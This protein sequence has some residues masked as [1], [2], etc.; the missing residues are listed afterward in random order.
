[1]LSYS[2]LLILFFGK[3]NVLNGGVYDAATKEPLPMVNVVIAGTE[4]GTVTDDDGSYSMILSDSLNE[5]QVRYSMIGYKPEIRNIKF[6]GKE[7]LT[8]NIS[9][10]MEPLKAQGILVSAKKKQFRNSASITPPALSQKDL[11]MLPSFVE[12]DL[13][14]TIETLPGVTKSSDFSTAVSVR[15]GG[16]DQNLVLIDDVPL[17]NPFHLFGLVSAFNSNAVK[18]AELYVSGIPIKDDASLS[19]VLDLKTKSVDREI[20]GLSGVA[21]LS[22]LSGGLTMGSKIPYLNSSFL[23]SVRRTYADKLLALFDYDLPY[24]F[25]DGY[26]HWETEINDWSLVLSGYTGE[27]FL[28]IRDNDDESIKIIG[29]DWGNDVVALN[30]FHSY[31]EGDLFHMFAGYS[32]HDFFLRVIDTLFLTDGNIDVGTIGAE[33]TKKFKK[34][35]ITVGL[36]DCYN[37]FAYNVN[38]LMGY[39]YSY[40]DI[41]SNRASLYM[42][43]K[44]NLS[45]KILFLGG[46][47]FTYYY[48]ESEEFG[49]R[50]KD[51]LRAYR[52]SAKYF[53]DDLRAISF[54]FGNFHQ[55]IVP[56]GSVMGDAGEG[57]DIPIYYWV[58]LGGAYDPEEAHHFNL[59][60][61][62]WLREDIYFS[63][64]GYYR[65]YNRLLNMKDLDD[66]EVSNEREYYESMLEE[67]NGKAYGLDF[68]LKKE[69]GTLRGW[70]SYS[71]LKTSAHFGN[72]TYPSD[73][74]RNHNLHL[75]LL[76]SLGKKY[77]AGVQFAFCT[78][79]P[80]TTDLARLRYRKE[81]MPYGEDEAEWI[82]LKGDKNQVRYPPYIRLDASLSR[83]F[84]FGNNELDLKL[85]LYN[86]LN[87][88]NVF[89]YYYDY[90]PEPPVKEPFYMLPFIPS[91]EFIYKF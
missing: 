4:L 59:G 15:G 2:F 75:T 56:G 87:S 5:F 71:F 74:D 49:Q 46:V 9:M 38:F 52:L 90:G 34:H 21:S 12:G 86:V 69:I 17:L 57:V 76:S 7:Y 14:R 29:F 23:I 24:Y 32:N 25:Y 61:E 70:I 77:E 18:S 72:T 81:V 84:Y 31:T 45:E 16:A 11:M 64:E 30:L 37:P 1:M 79:N 54:S 6:G 8:I 35:E 80:Y 68:L 47:S 91:I 73:W 48:S 19:S 36:N 41:W 58:P 83:S 78:G 39:E 53:F 65:N 40:D 13:M 27:D 26:L 67:G 22:L 63:L 43:D 89:M 82:E 42:E 3:Y 66:I 44:F 50:N 28:D 33:Y 60:L 85:S 55:Y 88:K 62:G 20:E 51:F 10:R